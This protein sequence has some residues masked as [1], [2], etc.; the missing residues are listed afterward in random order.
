MVL[1]AS[2]TFWWP[3]LPTH[4]PDMYKMH[5][6]FVATSVPVQ[7]RSIG[8][9]LTIIFCLSPL[10]LLHNGPLCMVHGYSTEATGFRS[11][12]GAAAARADLSWS[13]WPVNLECTMI[14]GSM[15]MM[16]MLLPKAFCHASRSSWLSFA[17][18]GTG[19][20]R[21]FPGLKL[22][23]LTLT[24]NLRMPFLREYLLLHGLS[25]VSRQTCLTILR[26]SASLYCDWHS[27]RR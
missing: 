7:S 25:D 18:E 4:A 26:R 13:Y 22:H 14:N 6:C 2:G 24:T 27:A 12:I 10:S 1:P 20:S 11:K 15:K 8:F 3:D 19:F 9:T 21:K 16:L 23:V 17:T 5:H